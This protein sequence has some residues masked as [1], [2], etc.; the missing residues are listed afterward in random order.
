[1]DLEVIFKVLEHFEKGH[2]GGSKA[3]EEDEMGFARGVGV[4]YFMDVLFLRDEDVGDIELLPD[5]GKLEHIFVNMHKL[6]GHDGVFRDGEGGNVV[7]SL[8]LP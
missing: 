1:M 8:Q 6:L 3:V 4:V 7:L 5:V 2:R